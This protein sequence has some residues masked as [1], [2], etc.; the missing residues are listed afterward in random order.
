MAFPAPLPIPN[1]DSGQSLEGMRAVEGIIQS[2]SI[3]PSDTN[4]YTVT[5]DGVTQY[6]RARWLY[7]GISGDVTVKKWDGNN[8]TYTNLAAGVWH[9]IHTIGVMSTNTDPGLEMIWGN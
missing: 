4:G 8:Q 3:T 5:I 2:G 6:T 1:Y 9:P 7:L